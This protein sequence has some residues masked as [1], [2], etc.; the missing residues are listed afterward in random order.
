MCHFPVHRECARKVSRKRLD[1][2]RRNNCCLPATFKTVWP[3]GLRR[4]LQAP[5]RK[6]VGSNPT[7]V[8]QWLVCAQHTSWWAAHECVAHTTEGC[9]VDTATTA[10]QRRGSNPR[11]CELVLGASTLDHSAK[12]S[13]SLCQVFVFFCKLKCSHTAPHRAVPKPG[14]AQAPRGRWAQANSADSCGV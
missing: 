4:W 13:V 8:M 1:S 3:S 10:R 2:K 7:A 9:G 14:P 5:V 11:P 6:G 12:L